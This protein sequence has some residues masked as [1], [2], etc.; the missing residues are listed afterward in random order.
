MG[1]VKEQG[2]GSQETWFQ[3]RGEGGKSRLSPHLE[4]PG[5]GFTYDQTS[6]LVLGGSLRAILMLSVP[7][8]LAHSTAPAGW[9]HCS[10]NAQLCCF[11]V[12]GL[13]EVTGWLSLS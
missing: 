8:A 3:S 10:L 4:S 1:P 9:T 11:L 13:R 5:Q 6:D 2:S 12:W 7:W